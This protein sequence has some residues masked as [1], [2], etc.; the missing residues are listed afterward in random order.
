[1]IPRTAISDGGAGKPQHDK[2]RHSPAE[3]GLLVQWR[4]V[5]KASHV[6]LG[7]A[8]HSADPLSQGVQ[9]LIHL[10]LWDRVTSWETHTGET[11]NAQ[12]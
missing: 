3:E 9:Y 12:Q 6:V 2:F 10:R 5:L 4:Q 7:P 8:E 1:M 11:I